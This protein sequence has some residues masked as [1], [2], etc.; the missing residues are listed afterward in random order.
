MN[1]KLNNEQ[2]DKPVN[3]Q[4]GAVGPND[5][6]QVQSSTDGNSNPAV[7]P[8]KGVINQQDPQEKETKVPE[9]GQKPKPPKITWI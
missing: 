2:N 7:Y 5:T 1:D 9:S 3:D 4:G 6:T 8:A